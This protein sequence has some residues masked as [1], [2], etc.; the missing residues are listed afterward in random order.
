MSE[1]HPPFDF[2]TP[3]GAPAPLVLDSPHSGTVYPAGFSP[4][5]PLDWLRQTEDRHVDELFSEA[6]AQGAA[7]LKARV[8]RSFID[9]NR[10]EDDLDPRVIAGTGLSCAP[11]ERALAGHGLVRT[12]C[13][14]RPVY[15]GPLQAGDVLRRITRY[16]RPYHE[17]LG[18][19]LAAAR[20]QCGAVWHLNCHSMPTAAPPVLG[21]SDGIVL[22]DLDGESCEPEFASFVQAVLRRMG[23]RVGRN[24]PYKGGE[25][26]ARH[27]GPAR[28]VHSL[29]IEIS[30]ALYMNEETLKSAPGFA[31]LKRDL[32]TLLCELRGWTLARARP[33][34][35]AAE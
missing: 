13:R 7:L 16:Y 33:F 24:D 27:G 3:R 21:G 14:G 28:G 2:E 30:R 6:P 17:K 35:I 34:R 31:R 1:I 8:A 25:I 19:V 18:Q 9:L 23:Y 11:T 26:V 29:Q 32:T 10:A 5:I 4:D 22:G 12:L 20:A 15:P